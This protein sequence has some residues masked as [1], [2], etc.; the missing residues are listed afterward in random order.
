MKGREI[1]MDTFLRTSVGDADMSDMWKQGAKVVQRGSNAAWDFDK[2]EPVEGL[3]GLCIAIIE[4]YCRLRC[5]ATTSR[6]YMG[7]SSDQ[8]RVGDEI[9]I[10]LVGE[11]YIHRLMDLEA[12]VLLNKNSEMYRKSI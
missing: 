6:R 10:R 5:L 3:D 4:V 7:L 12:V 1:E 8:S 2:N 9:C 11:C